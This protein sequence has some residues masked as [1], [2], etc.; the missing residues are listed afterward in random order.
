MENLW[1]FHVV[2]IKYRVALLQSFPDTN[3]GFT[4]THYND[5]FI[6]SR[7]QPLKAHPKNGTHVPTKL[8]PFDSLDPVQVPIQ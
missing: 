2:P 6:N 1:L 4:I 7:L 8:I 5:T 3:V